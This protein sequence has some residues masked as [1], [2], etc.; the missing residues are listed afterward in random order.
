MQ[1]F[2]LIKK[3]VLSTEKLIVNNRSK[4]YPKIILSLF[5]FHG[6]WGGFK[7][8]ANNTECVGSKELL[9]RNLGQ[10]ECFMKCYDSISCVYYSFG[11]TSTIGECWS[12]NVQT[13]KSGE[14]MRT[15]QFDLLVLDIG[16]YF[17]GWLNEKFS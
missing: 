5:C 15:N 7:L 4:N 1:K 13:C 14:L 6:I 17:I 11:K 9:G 10:W 16:N 3:N 2:L 8:V 12:Q